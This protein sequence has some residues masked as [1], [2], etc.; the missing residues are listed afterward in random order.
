MILASKSDGSDEEAYS[1]F[2]L[3]EDMLDAGP[4]RGL[5]GIGAPD[6]R[7]HRAT[8]GFLR[9]TW[10]VKPLRAGNASFFRER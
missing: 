8:T 2:L 5:A 6:R 1:V 3:G 9:W 4:H 7:R 10:L